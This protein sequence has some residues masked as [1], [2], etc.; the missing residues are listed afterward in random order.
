MSLSYLFRAYF[1]DGSTFDQ[2]PNDKAR[3]DHPRKGTGSA[4][5]DLLWLLETGQKELVAFAL[6]KPRARKP[7]I[8]VHL[9]D[10]HFELAAHDFWAGP[11]WRGELPAGVIRQLIYYRDVQQIASMDVNDATGEELTGWRYE[12]KVV[13]YLGWQATIDTP[14][15]RGR[16]VQHVIGLD[17][18]ERG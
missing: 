12:T 13:T 1:A 9:T 14:D 8:A 4:F 16:N 18:P 3:L 11:E 15:G 2:T 10:G 7:F 6:R 17:S 5:T